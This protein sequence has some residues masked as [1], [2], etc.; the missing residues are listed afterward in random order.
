MLG[1][2]PVTS[3]VVLVLLMSVIVNFMVSDLLFWV[4]VRLSVDLVD[5]LLMIRMSLLCVIS[6]LIS[7][8]PIKF[9]F[10]VTIVCTSQFSGSGCR[11]LL[12]CLLDLMTVLGPIMDRLVT[13]VFAVILVF[14]LMMDFLT[15]VFF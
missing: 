14:G 15:W 7:V 9:V 4:S 6:W 3:L 12:S 5:R 2:W 13:M 8:E 1:W 11:I 10:L